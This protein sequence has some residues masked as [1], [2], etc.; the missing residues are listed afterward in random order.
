MELSYT[1]KITHKEG[2][3]EIFLITICS[4]AGFKGVNLVQFYMRTDQDSKM[5]IR[6]YCNPGEADYPNF[7]NK[8]NKSS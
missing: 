7:I 3:F 5:L 1:T 6:I 8:E 2:P 4:W